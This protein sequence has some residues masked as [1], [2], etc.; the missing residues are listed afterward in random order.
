MR[1]MIEY[2][3][4]K[5]TEQISKKLQNQEIKT[6][7]SKKSLLLKITIPKETGTENLQAKGENVAEKGGK[8]QQSND[9]NGPLQKA[10]TKNIFHVNRP[11]LEKI[12]QKNSQ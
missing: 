12:S 7:S 4:A 10:L 3:K 6:N 2:K 1:E 5:I 8:F 11:A 9:F